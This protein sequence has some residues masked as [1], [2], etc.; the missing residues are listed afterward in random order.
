MARTLRSD[1]CLA[2][3]ILGLGLLL[4][5]VGSM[6]LDQWRSADHHHQNFSFEDLLGFLANGVGIA[7]V[8]WWVLSLLLAVVASLLHRSGRERG[9]NTFAKF[10]PAFMLRLAVAVVSVNLLGVTMAQA[11]PPPDPGW[12][13]TTASVETSPHPAWRPAPVAGPASSSQMSVADTT[14]NAGDPRWKPKAPAPDPGLLSRPS[15]RQEISR[16]AGVVVKAGDSLWSLAASRLGPFATDVEVALMWPKW[17]A[18]NLTVI[19]GDP[20]VLTPGQVLRPP[21]PD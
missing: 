2:A 10:S 3:T 5:H 8:A 12:G 13:P 20:S 9:A 15:S 4:V 1:A 21:A 14:A 18:A 16:D 11:T 17:Y 6:L 7:L 19:G